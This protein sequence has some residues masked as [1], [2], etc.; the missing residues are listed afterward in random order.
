MLGVVVATLSKFECAAS[1]D[2][3]NLVHLRDLP[4]VAADV[5]EDEP[6]SQRQVAERQFLCAEP[7]Q[8]GVEENGSRDDE[9]GAT[10][11]EARHGQT[12]RGIER[13]DLFTQA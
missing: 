8:D 2:V 13:D 3:R 10:R 6:F 5:I 7:T 11:I 12:L 4:P 1:A 9:I